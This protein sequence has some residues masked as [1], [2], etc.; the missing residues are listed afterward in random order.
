MKAIILAAGKGTRLKPLT[1]TTPKPMLKIMGR[2]LLEHIIERL[3]EAIDE[4]VIITGY[5]E[6]QIKDYFGVNFNN[7]K[8][9]YVNQ[10]TQLGTGHAALLAA[11][12]LTEGEKFLIMYADDIHDKESITQCLEHDLSM[13]VKNV[14]NP[15]AFGV[16][17]LDQNGIIQEIEEKPENPKSNLVN[18]GVYVLD[19]RVFAYQPP[20]T[21]SGEYYLTDMVVSLTR[22]HPVKAIESNFWLPVGTPQ[23]LIRA[24]QELGNLKQMQHE[25]VAI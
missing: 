3:P 2:P 4:L 6:E 9:Q 10:P 14:V 20:L 15:K 16:V 1:D 24:E 12:F 8:V 21:K 13:L 23:D 19:T 22:N 11:P 7:R 17:S 25:Y 5:K 18:V